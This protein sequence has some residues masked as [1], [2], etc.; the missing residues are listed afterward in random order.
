MVSVSAGD[1][2]LS[3]GVPA[4]HR[5]AQFATGLLAIRTPLATVEIAAVAHLARAQPAAVPQP[6]PVTVAAP[7][8]QGVQGV[9]VGKV[10]HAIGVIVDFNARNIATS[11]TNM[12]RCVGIG[13]RHSGPPR[14]LEPRPAIPR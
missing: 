5:V 9:R 6:F 2:E 3:G 8:P 7:L 13:T 12:E 11:K 14:A 1:S 10:T 4:Q